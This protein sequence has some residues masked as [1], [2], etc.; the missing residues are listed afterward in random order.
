[1]KRKILAHIGLLF[2]LA[3]ATSAHAEFVNGSFENNFADWT[4]T[5][6]PYLVTMDGMT[7]IR[8]NYAHYYGW[9]GADVWFGNNNAAHGQSYAVIGS[10]GNES[11]GTLKTSLWTANKQFVS[12]SHAG[13]NTS[14]LPESSKAYASI[15]DVNGIELQRVYVTSFNDSVWRDFS[16][17]LSLA[18]L[19]FGDQFY[20]EFVDGYSWSVLDNVSQN[21]ANLAGGSPAPVNGPMV[22]LLALLALGGMGVRNIRRKA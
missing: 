15:L 4:V 8:D 13:N 3:F 18:G 7:R 1:M 5:G 6:D 17:D 2:G 19:N 20:F 9:E 10:N 21:G 11:V 22:G 16:L 12:F 14:W